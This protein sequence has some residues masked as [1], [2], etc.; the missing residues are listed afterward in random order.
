MTWEQ[1]EEALEKSDLRIEF[2]DSTYSEN[3][4]PNT[5]VS[6]VPASGHVVKR[7]RKIYVVV[8]TG[9]VPLVTVPQLVNPE[10]AIALRLARSLLRNAGLNTGKI[11]YM[12]ENKSGDNFFVV[13]MSYNGRRLLAGDRIPLGS[14]VDLR[15]SDDV[16]DISIMHAMM[17]PNIPA[18]I[19][20]PDLAGNT[21]SESRI[22]LELMRLR[23][24]KVEYG[25]EV[26]DSASA[27]VI[28]QNPPAY[29]PPV[30]PGTKIDLKLE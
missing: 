23:I 14:A 21:L 6:Q 30:M 26:Q 1:A 15:V 28:D 13:S 7:G 27:I 10:K 12:H 29:G 16:E 20:V 3:H 24:G 17:D 25:P 11:I 19:A 4:E 9:N 2:N 8:N 5:I 18:E 22:V